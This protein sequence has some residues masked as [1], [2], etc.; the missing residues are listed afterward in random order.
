LVKCLSQAARD[1]GVVL[2]PASSDCGADSSCTEGQ[3]TLSALINRS[4]M[5]LQHD[6]YSN[7]LSDLLSAAKL[8]PLDK[9]ICQ[10]AGIC[11]HKLA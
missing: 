8:S 2:L 10:T 4:L 6:D 11:Y 1:Y 5:Y 3:L 7:A 9:T